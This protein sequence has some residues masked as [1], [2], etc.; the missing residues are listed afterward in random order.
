MQVRVVEPVKR[1]RPISHEVPKAQVIVGFG[2]G[3]SANQAAPTGRRCALP[4]FF[5]ARVNLCRQRVRSEDVCVYYGIAK[6]VQ[7]ICLVGDEWRERDC[8]ISRFDRPTTDRATHSR[9]EHRHFTD[10]RNE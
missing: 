1:V 9:N 7:R 8:L 2:D 6:D 5:D 3:L 4:R 10:Y